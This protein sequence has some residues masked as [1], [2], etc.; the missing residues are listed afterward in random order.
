MS[1]G[2]IA[3]R[4]TMTAATTRQALFCMSCAAKDAVS[5]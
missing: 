1:V 4:H 2:G 5:Q 3:P